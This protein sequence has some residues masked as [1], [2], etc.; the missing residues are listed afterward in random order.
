LVIVQL[1]EGGAS[2]A[3]GRRRVR[4]GDPVELA[5]RAVACRFS[6]SS[7][8]FFSITSGKRGHP[9]NGMAES[10]SSGPRATPTCEMREIHPERFD[11][12]EKHAAAA[13]VLLDRRARHSIPLRS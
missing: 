4:I 8:D 11:L 3:N 13:K 7:E 12:W 6:A 1:E 2:P 5:N 10:S 9:R